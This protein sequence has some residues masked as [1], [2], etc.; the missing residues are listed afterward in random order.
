MT[1]KQQDNIAKA[2][3]AVCFGLSCWALNSVSNARVTIAKIE[4]Q[5]ETLKDE[6]KHRDVEISKLKDI[7]TENSATNRELS[8]QLKSVIKILEHLEN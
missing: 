3:I 8:L 2:F 5:V 4:Q 1:L 7:V 6:S